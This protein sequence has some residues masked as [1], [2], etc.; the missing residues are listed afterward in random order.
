MNVP[1]LSRNLLRRQVLVPVCFAFALGLTALATIPTTLVDFFQPGTQPGAL[2]VFIVQS[3]SCAF[4]HGRYEPEYEPYSQWAA[5]MMAQSAR[6]PIFYACVAIANNDVAEV[7]DLCIRCHAPVA[8]LEG[9]STPTNGTAF[10]SKD[11]DG[12]TCHVCHRFVDPIYDPVNNPPD[13]AQI[14]ADLPDPLVHLPHSGQYIVDPEDRRRGP[15]DMD[16]NFPFHEWRRS[17]FHRESLLCST[18]HDV[19]NPAF[20]RQPDGS[21]DLGPINQAHPTHNKL[22]QFPIERTFSEWS[23][24]A[25]AQGPIEMGGRFGGNITAVSSCQDCHMPKTYGIACVPDLGFNSYRNDLPRHQFNGAN[26]WVL[27]A[28]RSLYPDYET[29]L[30]DE[31]VEAAHDRTVEMLQAASDAEVTQL[32]NE[33]HVR[34]INQTGHKLPTGYPEGRRMWLNVKFFDATDTLVA[35]RGAYD[36]ETAVLIPDTK[37][38]EAKLGIDEDLAPIVNL[39]VGPSFHFALNNKWFFDNRIPPRGFTN[40]A[41]AAVQAGAIGYAYA[42]GQYWDDTTYTLPYTARRAEIRLYY[43]T[44]TKEYIEFLLANVPPP[45]PAGQIAYDQW[46]LHGKSAPVEMDFVSIPLAIPGDLDEDGDVDLN[47]LT[48]VLSAFGWSDA[49]DVNGDGDTDLSDLTL[50]LSYFGTVD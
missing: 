27:R 23:A 13:D 26:T 12:V 42:D 7:G 3:Q 14:L 28:V 22:D 48:I 8:W 10:I 15:F 21:Y 11:F 29:G 17:P 32:G 19:S 4:C 2:N 43:Q 37:V 20:T 36:F 33:L 18:C 1:K 35:E 30:S 5:S 24:S 34:I 44:T 9:R 16:P 38:Y 6:D 49:G 41:F 47:D 46:V 39:P 45:N 31:S 40:A 50:L 25:F